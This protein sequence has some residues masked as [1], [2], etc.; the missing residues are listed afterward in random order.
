MFPFISIYLEFL[1]LVLSVNCQG[2]IH[3][4]ILMHK[5]LK[6]ERSSEMYEL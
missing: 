1:Q 2:W 5:V 4:L 6:S 3:G